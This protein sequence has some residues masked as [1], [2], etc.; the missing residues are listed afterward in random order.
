VHPILDEE[1]AVRQSRFSINAAWFWTA[2]ISSRDPI[3][4]HS[5]NINVTAVRIFVEVAC[6]SYCQCA[7]ESF[8]YRNIF[9][10]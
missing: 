9:L 4:V 5:A 1:P 8:T 7:A 6:L 2:I 10:Y 3:A